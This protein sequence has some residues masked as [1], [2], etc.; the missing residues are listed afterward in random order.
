MADRWAT[1][2]VLPPGRGRIYWH[3]L[4]G[5]DPAVQAMADEARQRMVGLPG[6]HPTPPRWLHLTV[7]AAG[8][9]EHI[10]AAQVDTMR[11]EATRLLADLPP[12]TLT[13]DR[14]FYHPE[15]IITPARPADALAPLLH[16]ART[17]THA[18]TGY[19]G[20]LEHHPWTPH[21]TLAYST[22]EQPAAPIIN[23]LGTRLTPRR[24]TLTGLHLVNQDGPE[25]HWNWRPLATIPFGPR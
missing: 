5:E 6:L 19:D 18:A 14:V 3:V 15:A 13:F 17:A 21:V 7:L 4:L 20:S 25:H 24:V 12:I 9:A 23:A 8:L 1:R 2:T 11:S 22:A 10:T 16:A